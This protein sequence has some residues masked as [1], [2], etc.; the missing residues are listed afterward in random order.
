MARI[1][2]LVANFENKHF[3][4][5]IKEGEIRIEKASSQN[6]TALHLINK[7]L[8]EIFERDTTI[9]DTQYSFGP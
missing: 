7:S 4:E 9:F 8:F 5:L 1:L 6:K 3:L 2:L